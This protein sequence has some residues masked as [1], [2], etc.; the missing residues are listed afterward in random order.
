MLLLPGRITQDFHTSLA[1]ELC[2]SEGT[3]FA[4]ASSLIPQTLQA[5]PQIPPPAFFSGH[6]RF[7]TF[8]PP[9]SKPVI[10]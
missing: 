6:I 5:S 7:S 8:V 1:S 3:V 9:G 10:P 2:F 4:A